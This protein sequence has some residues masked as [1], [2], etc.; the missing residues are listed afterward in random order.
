MALYIRLLWASIRSRLQYKWDF[1]LTAVLYALLTAV[2]FVTV[3]AI[4]TRY[5]AIAGWRVS[6]VALLAGVS[7]TSFGLFRTFGSELDTFDRYLVQG[8]F[9][10]L[11]IR[12]WPSLATLLSRNFDL[13]RAGAIAQG[14][15][16]LTIGVTGVLREGAPTWVAVYAYVLPLAGALVVGAC[17]LATAAAGFWL[18]RVSDLLTFTVSAPVT[19]ANYPMEI[20][21]RWL[22]WLFTGVLPV[23]TTGYLPLRYA[24][25]K[26]GEPYFLVLP[27]VCGALAASAAYRFWRMGEQRYQSTGN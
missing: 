10:N 21:P 13:G 2:D 5:Q 26:G 24:L 12:P 20:F 9:D 15:L 3:A 22:R 6:E 7:G 1:A 19:A 25:G 14:L 27:F 11:L 16:I 8:E 18:T 23:A 17:A 4:L